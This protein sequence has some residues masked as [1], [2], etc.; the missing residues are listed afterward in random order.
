MAVASACARGRREVFRSLFR[1]GIRRHQDRLKL[2]WRFPL[3][4]TFCRFLC[5]PHREATNQLPKHHPKQRTGR[6][7]THIADPYP[8]D[9]FQRSAHCGE[10]IDRCLVRFLGIS[11]FLPCRDPV[12]AGRVMLLPRW[13]NLVGFPGRHKL[14]ATDV[15][16]V[17]GSF[18][19]SAAG[20]G[21]WCP[22]AMRGAL[23]QQGAL[24]V[25]AA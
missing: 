24:P 20:D 18:F 16:G 12:N 21:G 15:A 17:H 8:Y 19:T 5:R 23:A 25:A 7:Q 22:A 10:H 2:N 6:A 9:A 3:K 1:R 4:T 13:T 11:I 14:D